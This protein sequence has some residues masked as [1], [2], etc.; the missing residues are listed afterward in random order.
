MTSPVIEAMRQSLAIE[1]KAL[2]DLYVGVGDGVLA[3]AVDL[4]AQ[5]PLVAT[6]GSGTSG[7]AAMKLAHTLCC[8]QRPATFLSPALALHGGLGFV[9]AGSALVLISR[10]GNTPELLAVMQGALRRDARLIVVTQA[11]TSQLAEHAELVIPMPVPRESD[12]LNVMATTSFV[13]T[14][15]IFDALIAGLI[16]KTGYTKQQFGPIH[17]GGAVGARLNALGN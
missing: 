4:L 16:E 9:Q 5:A 13:V 2:A 11:P 17:P 6:S 15:A 10:G 8:I 14:V 1:A 7:I 3:Q 12:P